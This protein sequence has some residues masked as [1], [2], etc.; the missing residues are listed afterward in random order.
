MDISI[1]FP[2]A[3]EDY[4]EMTPGL[5]AH[6]PVHAVSYVCEAP[7]GFETVIDLPQVIA[8]LG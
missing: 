4:A 8:K 2:V 1:T 7:P 5:T 3:Q 6:P